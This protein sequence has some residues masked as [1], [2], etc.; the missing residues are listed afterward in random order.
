MR[1]KSQFNNSLGQNLGVKESLT[2][3]YW[4]ALLSLFVVMVVVVYSV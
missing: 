1:T 2:F 3:G 4:L